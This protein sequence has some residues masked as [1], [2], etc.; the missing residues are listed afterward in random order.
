MNNL[1]FDVSIVS[2]PGEIVVFDPQKTRTHQAAVD[3]LI[4]ACA[5]MER[6][7]DLDR[8]VDAKIEE[9]R[10]FVGWWDRT[11]R[12]KGG[13]GGYTD[14]AGSETSLTVT[15]AKQRTGM[16][17]V[18]VS[19]WRISLQDQDAYHERI[20][21]AAK[22][23]AYLA[24]RDNHRAQGTGLNDWFTPPVYIEAA[25]NVMGGIDLDPATHP[26]APEIADTFYTAED[27]GLAHDWHGRVWLNPPYARGLVDRFVEKLVTEVAAGRTTQ[28]IMLT[29]SY[30]D[31][32]WFHAAHASASAI[33]FTLSRIK[34]T[35]ADGDPARP[36]QGQ[37]FFY[38][39][40]RVAKFRDAFRKHGFIDVPYR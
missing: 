3:S 14:V 15:I 30:T 27:D 6:W 7:D 20:V 12:R 8:A 28:A 40:R 18:Q 1:S 19:R 11:V 37:A 17:K 34:F 35:D 21:S 25:R 22:L 16:T 39:G 38:F 36:T 26:E 2:G 32:A 23:A 5:Q 4:A 31:T 9:Q 24:A 10:L 29:H 33:C 13:D